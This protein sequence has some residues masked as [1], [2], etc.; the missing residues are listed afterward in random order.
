[1]RSATEPSENLGGVNPMQVGV[2]MAL[3][4]ITPIFTQGAMET[5]G[6]ITDLGIQGDGF[7]ILSDGR[8]RFYTR[9][10]DFQFDNNGG[11]V[12][13]S[14]GFTVQGR[15]ADENGQIVSGTDVQDVK[16]PF[17]SILAARATTEVKLGGNLDAGAVPD[18][19]MLE[20]DQVYGL[21]LAGQDSD[22]NGLLAAGNT[23]N[24]VDGMTAGSTTVTVTDG[25]AV[26]SRTY[27][28]ASQDASVGDGAF[29]SLDDLLAEI[30]NDYGAT[31]FTAALGANGR[32][33]LTDTSA[34]ANTIA[35]TSTNAI[36]ESALSAANGDVNAGATSTDQF[37]HVAT[38]TDLLTNLYNASGQSLGLIAG[39]EV[40]IDGVVGASAVTTGTLA[41]GAASTYQELAD[42][43][44][45]TFALTNSSGV[46]ISSDNGG[47]IINGDG[48][49]ANEISLVNLSADDTPGA[50]GTER[51][52]FNS[53]FGVSA[54]GWDETQ[55]ADDVRHTSSIIIYDSL[56]NPHTVTLEFV[57][58]VTNVNQW[59]WQATT[60][61]PAR[62]TS[63]GSGFVTF[64]EDGSLKGFE[65]ASGASSLQFEAGPGTQNPMTITFDAGGTTDAS[66]LTQ[67]S[68]S[69]NAIARSQDG[70]RA[71][72]LESVNID[73]YGNVSGSYGNGI[74]RKLAQI[75]LGVFTNP[76]GLMK[77]GD[78]LY[79][80]S[81]NSQIV[82]IRS[83]G[84]DIPSTIISGALEMSNVD[85]AQEFTN[86]IIAQR[87]FQ[88]NARVITT[89]D[90]MLTELVNLKR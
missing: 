27:I 51:S 57:K 8:D 17:G 23:N 63:G 21:E 33:T 73:R 31:S 82:L 48:G 56:G 16:L 32:I 66:G 77:T 54:G 36:L 3:G 46:Q 14:N 68:S 79:A 40:T 71:G 4:R 76:N 64:N 30:N 19:T 69:S 88:A 55:A 6:Q 11:L 84:E 58:D 29:N 37:L 60:E 5:T 20:S 85:L 42:L 52:N 81:P 62:I 38:G 72:V 87:G 45:T 50:G 28:Y 78:N 22:I 47:L 49:T 90:E 34:A 53:I 61:S 83:A 75:V 24:T 41:I 12:S 7:F 43:I 18:G 39:D 65:Y 74:T 25:G 80:E 1:L 44:E 86:M 35:I 10:G 15:P 2:G 13:A 89:S 26:G 59:N 70:Y 67:F 9:A